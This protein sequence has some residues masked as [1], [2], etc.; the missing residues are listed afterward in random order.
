MGG[1][2]DCVRQVEEVTAR[3]E[4]QR[5]SLIQIA[6]WIHDEYAR[7]CRELNPEGEL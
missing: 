2:R 3:L 1:Y 6:E 7:I 4:K 5:A